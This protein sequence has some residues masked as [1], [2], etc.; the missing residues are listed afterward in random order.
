MP[1][2]RESSQLGE[3]QFGDLRKLAAAWASAGLDE[4][5]G[6]LIARA[7][8][9]ARDIADEYTA[10]TDGAAL[11]RAEIIANLAA[12][13]MSVAEALE[14][15]RRQT[16]RAEDTNRAR[17][18]RTLGRSAVFRGVS[19]TLHDLEPIRTHLAPAHQ[20]IIDAATPL[21]PLID[22][23]DDD[24]TAIAATPKVRDAWARLT[25]L[26]SRRALLLDVRR[27][28][29]RNRIVDRHD[30]NVPAEFI[31]YAR[32]DRLPPRRDLKALPGA[33]YIAALIASGSQPGMYTADEAAMNARIVWDADENRSR[34]FS[35][36]VTPPPKHEF[37]VQ[38]DPH[39]AIE[40]TVPDAQPHQ[41]PVDAA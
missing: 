19:R 4:T 38:P 9:R 2:Y 34:V 40:P 8:E 7:F 21:V 31:V 25:A 15:E 13:K 41:V 11:T 1:T 26:S 39:G 36:D 29:G 23:I 28:L 32:P 33:R 30:D 27:L 37:P 12:G 10:A 5:I 22:G 35:D 24:A 20:E 17:E 6:E 18:L 3:I 16:A 14:T